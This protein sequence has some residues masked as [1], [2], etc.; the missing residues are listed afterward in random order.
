[1]KTPYARYSGIVF[2]TA[3][4]LYALLLQPFVFQSMHAQLKQQGTTPLLGIIILLIIILELPALFIKSKVIRARLKHK[5]EEGSGLLMFGWMAHAVLSLL[6]F[7]FAVQSFGF[8]ITAQDLPLWITIGMFLVVIKELAYLLGMILATEP[9][10]ES[11]K[12]SKEFLADIILIAFACVSFTT[13]WELSA[14]QPGFHLSSYSLG[15]AIAQGIAAFMIFLIAFYGSRLPF[16]IEEFQQERTPTQQKI[17][18]L[19]FFIA[20]ITAFLPIILPQ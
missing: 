17:T 5:S 7:M 9:L 18:Y 6:L 20:I 16:F 10:K 8:S 11:P 13:L 3:F 14:Q 12:A 15:E 1:M 4:F 19:S 2:N